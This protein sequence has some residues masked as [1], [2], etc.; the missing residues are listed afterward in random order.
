MYCNGC[1][2]SLGNDVGA[3]CPHCGLASPAHQAQQDQNAGYSQ[4]TYPQNPHQTP[5][6][7]HTPYPS[8]G[9]HSY[10]PGRGK[11]IAS[12]ALGI[13]SIVFS[14]IPVLGL[15]LG[16]IGLAAASMAGREGFVGGMRTGGFVCSLIGTI[17]SSIFTLVCIPVCIAA[18]GAWRWLYWYW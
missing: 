5:Y 6:P 11:A 9:S 18:G 2:H 15:V 3:N 17:F 8:Y 13:C 14:S 12:L 4:P 16:I 7:Q 10:Q 1:G